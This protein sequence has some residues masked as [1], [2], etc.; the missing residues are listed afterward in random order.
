MRSREPLRDSSTRAENPVPFPGDWGNDHAARC[1]A[2]SG[3]IPR[4][5]WRGQRRGA[6]PRRL[7]AKGEGEMV[8][9]QAHALR[10]IETMSG[11]A[12]DA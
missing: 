8:A 6:A 2:R 7:L 11:E 9:G 10:V 1:G 4:R 5:Y 12:V 3:E